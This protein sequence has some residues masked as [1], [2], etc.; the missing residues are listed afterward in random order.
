M[1][2]RS[3][4]WFVDLLFPPRCVSCGRAASGLCAAC[5]ATLRPLLPPC[6]SR[7][8]A[9][10]AWPVA[11]CRECAGRR[12][13]F[14][15]ARAAFA[16]AGP[17]RPFVQAWK[18]HGLRRLAPLAAELVATHLGA[19]VADVIT[20]IPPDPARQLTRSRHPAEALATELARAWQ[21]ESTDLLARKGSPRRQATLPRAARRANVAGS[22]AATARSPARVVLVDDVYTTGSTANAAASALRAAGA[23]RVDIVTFARAVR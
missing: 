13:A 8:G 5:R 11:R 10:T 19:P 22:F 6:C 17:A 4:A 16:Y 9:P 18:E 2:V 20:Y 1:H 7:C 15:T 12:L 3:R 23:R 14:A 21:L